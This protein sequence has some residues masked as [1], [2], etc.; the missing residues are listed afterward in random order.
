MRI[1]AVEALDEIFVLIVIAAIIAV[2]VMRLLLWPKALHSVIH[3]ARNCA[4]AWVDVRSSLHRLRVH[5]Y[6][7]IRIHPLHLRAPSCSLSSA[8]TTFS[9]SDFCLQYEKK[10]R[11]TLSL[12][13]SFSFGRLH[14]RDSSIG[15]DSSQRYGDLKSSL[16]W[17]GS[18]PSNQILSFKSSF[19]IPFISSFVRWLMLS[20]FIFQ[21]YV[22]SN[23]NP[24]TSCPGK[25]FLG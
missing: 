14:K 16:G 1:V 25:V 10:K 11:K 20:L 17:E 5:G 3:I 7:V 9:F 8:S 21:V 12:R 15:K 24:S 2:I 4:A 6:C 13:K 23:N 19:N 18:S 22:H